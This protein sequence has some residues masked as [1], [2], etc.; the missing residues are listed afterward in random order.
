MVASARAA[1]SVPVPPPGL[2]REPPQDAPAQTTVASAS[3]NPRRT[4]TGYPSSG[5]RETGV[6]APQL[7]LLSAARP[8]RSQVRSYLVNIAIS[9]KGQIV[10]PVAIRERDGIEPGQEFELERIDRGK[11]RLIRLSSRANE[12]VVDWLLACARA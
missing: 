7:A 11:Y 9:T 4:G 12:G 2:E 3:A 5:L 6:T 8:D 1:A 10:I